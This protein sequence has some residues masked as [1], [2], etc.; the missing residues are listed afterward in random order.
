MLWR[1]LTASFSIIHFFL[2]TRSC[3]KSTKRIIMSFEMFDTTS[4]MGDY[5]IE[6]VNIN[7][8]NKNNER[9][10]KRDILKNI[11]RRVF[12]NSCR[13]VSRTSSIHQVKDTQIFHGF[14]EGMKTCGVHWDPGFIMEYTDCC[15]FSP[16]YGNSSTTATTNINPA[17]GNGGHLCASA[18]L[19]EFLHGNPVVWRRMTYNG[20]K[21]F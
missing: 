13:H 20:P 5:F 12:K 2:H 4:I 6:K 21:C 14:T 17:G 11:V 7:M 19:V 16:M 9:R 10:R 15:T 1:I 18:E 3:N 8:K